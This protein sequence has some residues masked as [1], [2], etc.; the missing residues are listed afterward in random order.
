MTEIP[1]SIASMMK[2]MSRQKRGRGRPKRSRLGERQMLR[3]TLELAAAIEIH[4]LAMEDRIDDTVDWSAAVRDLLRIAL[5]TE[6]MQAEQRAAA[7]Q[8]TP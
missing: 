6:Q 3:M 7:E 5:A 2:L 8:K 4:R 1:A